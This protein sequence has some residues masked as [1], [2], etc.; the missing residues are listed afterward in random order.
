MIRRSF[1]IQGHVSHSSLRLDCN[2]PLGT[3]VRM[4]Y[5]VR[6]LVIRAEA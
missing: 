4:F 2:P 3:G 6:G 5:P 1:A